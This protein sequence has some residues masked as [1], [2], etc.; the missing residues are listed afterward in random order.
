MISAEES[1]VFLLFFFMFENVG[2]FNGLNLL[3][4]WLDWMKSV[5]HKKKKKFQYY[6]IVVPYVAGNTTDSSV[7]KRLTASEH[8]SAP[9][10][11]SSPLSFNASDSLPW[12]NL[13]PWTVTHVQETKEEVQ[14]DSVQLWKTLMSRIAENR[15]ICVCPLNSRAVTHISK[16]HQSPQWCGG[17]SSYQLWVNYPFKPP[18]SNSVALAATIV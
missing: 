17:E 16:C 6:Y 8:L 4:T 18:A 1:C 5:I 11:R 2:D 9:P 15:H 14:S 7:T 3:N 13:F 10:P 12:R